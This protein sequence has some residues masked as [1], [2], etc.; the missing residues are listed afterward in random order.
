MAAH[1]PPRR[2][3]WTSGGQEPSRSVGPGS[4]RESPSSSGSSRACTWHD[5]VVDAPLVPHTRDRE[6]SRGAVGTPSCI[7]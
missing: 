4:A 1:A 5:D 6:V 2:D 3:I 7:E